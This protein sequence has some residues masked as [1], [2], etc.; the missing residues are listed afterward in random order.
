MQ[1][2]DVT[3]I[4]LAGGRA[5]RWGGRD[6]GL[7]EV[8][9]RPMISHVLDALATQVDQ[10]IISANRNLEEY[11]AF[12]VPVVTDA[13]GDFLGPLAGIASGLRAASTDWVAIAPCDSPLLAS[14]YIDRLASA[15][16]ARPETAVAV[17]HDGDR[18]QPAFALIRRELL[19]DLEA[20]L[21]SGERKLDRWYAR[22]PMQ[23]VNFSDSTDSFL[24]IN[25]AEDRDLLEARLVSSPVDKR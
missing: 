20:F 12:G 9:G 22:H 4:V 21:A 16:D 3:A 11:R 8:A 25:R 14:S 2:Q 15:R 5:T 19:D 18:I 24:N 13:T 6:K 7:I 1:R 17:A 23:P 10:I